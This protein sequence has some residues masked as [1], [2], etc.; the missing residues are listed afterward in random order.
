MGAKSSKDRVKVEGLKGIVQPFEVCLFSVKVEEN[1]FTLK[2]PCWELLTLPHQTPLKTVLL[3]LCD[4]LR[5]RHK[6]KHI[7]HQ[8]THFYLMMATEEDHKT[9]MTGFINGVWLKRDKETIM[10]GAGS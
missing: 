9:K 4:T 7:S 5:H 1:V 8:I 6:Y 10:S 2:S 3:I